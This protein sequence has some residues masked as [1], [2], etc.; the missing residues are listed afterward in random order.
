MYRYIA[1]TEEYFGATKTRDIYTKAIEV[2]PDKDTKD[3][4][5]RFA[6]LE[7]KLGE[8][9]RARAIL[10]HASQFCDPRT[11]PG[12]WKVCTVIVW[13]MFNWLTLAVWQEWNDFEVSHGNEDTFR[14]MLRVKRSVSAQFSAVNVV[15]QELLAQAAKQKEDE[16]ELKRRAEAALEATAAEL[17]KRKRE[18][19]KA[20]DPDT[21]PVEVHTI[22]AIVSLLSIIVLDVCCRKLNLKRQLSLH[23][24][25]K[26]RRMMMSLWK[27]R[28]PVKCLVRH[29]RVKQTART[30]LWVRWDC[31]RGLALG[32]EVNKDMQLWTLI[33]ICVVRECA[34]GGACL[35]GPYTPFK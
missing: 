22:A 4:C 11:E 29:C 17:E 10:V 30:N 12:F 32:C 28:F 34:R 7:R 20:W 24:M 8:I 26:T 25:T 21:A 16:K 1:K 6:A 3:M 33:F 9:D 15:T 35:S 5:L 2:L 31:S 23:R 14:E 19:P 13:W 18:R 27:S